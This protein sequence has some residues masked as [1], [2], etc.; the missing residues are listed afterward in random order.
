[1]ARAPSKGVLRQE[2]AKQKPKSPTLSS[3]CCLS[4]RSS[5]NTSLWEE[6]C[7]F[8]VLIFVVKLV[9]A[10]LVD[11]P[12]DGGRHCSKNGP[13]HLYSFRGL[14]SGTPV[15]CVSFSLVEEVAPPL[16]WYVLPARVDRRVSFVVHQPGAGPFP[17]PRAERPWPGLYNLF[18]PR[19]AL[20]D[21]GLGLLPKLG[22]F[23]VVLADLPEPALC[24]PVQGRLYEPL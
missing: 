7:Y 6:R 20:L 18:F 16:L 1:M 12:L 22:P 24:V 10:L 2:R 4:F 17:W 3:S 19:A 23:S 8:G 21:E 9:Q 11:L 15:H 13:S 14:G 5:I